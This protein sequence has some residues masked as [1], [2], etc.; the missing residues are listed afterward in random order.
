MDNTKQ[1]E[2]LYFPSGP[3]TSKE[4]VFSSIFLVYGNSVQG[5]SV[6]GRHFVKSSG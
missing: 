5:F 1:A 3:S 6:T 4:F 2:Q